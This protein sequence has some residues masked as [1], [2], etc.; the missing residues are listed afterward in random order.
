MKWSSDHSCP[1][2]YLWREFL[3][4]MVIKVIIIIIII[5]VLSN[6]Y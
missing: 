5:I 1:G 3:L 6:V 4:L 2:G